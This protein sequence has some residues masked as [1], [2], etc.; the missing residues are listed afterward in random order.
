[1][2]N[3]EDR[4]T[5]RP[6]DDRPTRRPIDRYC[7][8]ENFERPYLGNG[9]Y[10]PLHVFIYGRVFVVGGSKGAISGCTKSKMAT[11]RH[12]GKFQMSISPERDV[13]STLCL[14]LGWGFRGRRIEWTYFQLD[15]IQDG[16]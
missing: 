15:Q 12:L 10:D 2:Y 7:I 3:I 8:L 6:T 16:G 11:D 4:P 14:I 1:M 5:D 9:S 13:R